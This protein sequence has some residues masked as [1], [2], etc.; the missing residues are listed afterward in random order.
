MHF[1]K[2]CSPWRGGDSVGRSAGYFHICYF[3][4]GSVRT[5]HLEQLE[6]G[7][8]GPPTKLTL[9]SV[10]WHIAV[11]LPLWP[12]WNYNIGIWLLCAG[13]RQYCIGGSSRLPSIY[14]ITPPRPTLPPLGLAVSRVSE[15]STGLLRF[16][17][18]AHIS[19]KQTLALVHHAWDSTFC[20]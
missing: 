5:N 4:E 11:K 13:N 10:E 6:D 19:P 12:K 17:P 16:R 7:D 18:S 9:H 8:S 2:D 15:A 3:W 14:E 20:N 1:E